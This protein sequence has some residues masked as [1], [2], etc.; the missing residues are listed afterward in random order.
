MTKKNN[1]DIDELKKL[2]KLSRLK[3]VDE[4]SQRLI[5]DLNEII[6]F[7]DQLNEV[8]TENIKPLSSVTGHPLPLRDDKISD[9]NINSA[10]LKNA[11]EQNSGYFVVPKVV[12]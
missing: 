6:G 4:N 5:K 1:I 8:N 7:I 10:V 9:G 11:P 12:E 3:I 2:G